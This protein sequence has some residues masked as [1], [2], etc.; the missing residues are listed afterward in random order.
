MARTSSSR[1]AR[2]QTIR[3]FRSSPSP[4]QVARPSVTT[5]RGQRIELRA[6]LVDLPFDARARLFQGTPADAGIDVVRGLL[7][8]GQRQPFGERDDAV[9]DVAV[10]ADQHRQRPAG[11][12]IDELDLLQPLAL[13]LD[14]HHA[15]AARQSRQ[16]LAGIAEQILDG[17]APPGSGETA[18]DLARSSPLMSPT[19]SKPSTNRRKPVC[20]GSLPA[21]VC[22]A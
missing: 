15:G 11:P 3:L 17:A 10:L 9:L 8:R 21:L 1:C 5:L 6:A 13:L 22:G 14:Q 4:D 12:E 18:L 19:S 16:H 7:Q 20:V 2:P